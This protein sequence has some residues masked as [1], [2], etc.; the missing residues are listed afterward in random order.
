MGRGCQAGEWRRGCSDSGGAGAMYIIVLNSSYDPGIRSPVELLS[1]YRTMPGCSGGTVA[2][3]REAGY[4]Y[5]RV[6]VGQRFHHDAAIQ[7][8]GVAYHFVA[9]GLGSELGWWQGSSALEFVA[10]GECRAAQR[11][12]LPAVVHLHGLV[13]AAMV[14]RLRR[15]LPTGVPIV[16]QHHAE[17]P[18]AGLPGLYLRW[19]LSGVDG[20][21]FAARGLVDPWIRQGAI[22]PKTPV[23]EVMEG[24]TDFSRIDLPEARRRT[25][26]D[27]SPVVLWVGRLD[28]NKDPLTVLAG[29]EAVLPGFPGARIYMAHGEPSPLVGVVRHRIA[30]SEVLRRSVELLGSVPHSR[31]EAIF[32]SADYFILGSR[33]EGSGFALAEALACGVVPI[34]TDIP[35]FRMMTDGGAIGALWTPGDPEALASAVIEVLGR[36][37]AEQSRAARLFFDRRLSYA[38]IGRASVAAYERVMKTRNPRV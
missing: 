17:K 12:G 36:P 31:M 5:P 13:H 29:L 25:G 24:S 14:P 37:L 7:S 22:N 2:A 32:S 34:V 33:Y 11:E 16:V 9:D 26:M 23:F 20:V 18:R 19:A 35:S 30:G 1:R 38:A 27:G 15:A 4:S 21:F 8:G 28:D 10:V 6:T 3:A